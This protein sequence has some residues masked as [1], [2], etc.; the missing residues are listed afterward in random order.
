MPYIYFNLEPECVA[1]VPLPKSTYTQVGCICA[2]TEKYKDP[3]GLNFGR[4]IPISTSLLP[5]KYL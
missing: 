2:S 3:S 1:S 4:K 5:I